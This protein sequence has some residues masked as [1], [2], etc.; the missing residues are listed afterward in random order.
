MYLQ[1]IRLLP[2]LNKIPNKINYNDEQYGG[3]TSEISSFMPPYRTENQFFKLYLLPRNLLI[4]NK[5]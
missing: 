4:K 2:G 3:T 1:N 5:I